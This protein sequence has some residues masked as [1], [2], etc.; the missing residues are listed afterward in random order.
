MKQ[1]V[2]IEII[3]SLLILLFVYAASSK[4]IE[5]SAFKTQLMNQLFFKNFAGIFAWT[6]PSIE[7][8]TGL[9]LTVKVTRIIGLYASLIM[10]SFFTLYIAGMLLSGKQLPCSCEG[11][12]QQLSWNQ[13]LLF[14]LFFLLLSLISFLSFLS[15]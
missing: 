7:L 15:I 5:Y 6:I 13:H 8:L 10:L 12:I 11:I 4:L 2:A 3:S 1:K 14:N 9:L